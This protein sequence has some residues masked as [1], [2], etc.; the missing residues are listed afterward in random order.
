MAR[1]R[2][3][4]LNN[5]FDKV[6]QELGHT[7]TLIGAALRLL[8]DEAVN[9]DSLKTSLQTLTRVL[10]VVDWQ[11]IS[12]GDSEAWLYFYEDFLEEYDRRLRRLTGSYYT[13]PEVVGAMVHLV[14]EELRSSRFPRPALSESI[15]AWRRHLLLWPI[16]RPAPA[17]FC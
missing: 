10:G 15:P 2:N 1:A 6:A 9:Q 7:S 3:I 13:P 5:G 17:R 11:T 14:D 16:P 8:T 12:K 4:S